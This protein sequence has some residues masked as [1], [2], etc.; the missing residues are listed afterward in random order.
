MKL[1]ISLSASVYDFATLLHIS[2]EV[3]N[4]ENKLLKLGSFDACGM[5]RSV[6]LEDGTDRSSRN[7]GNQLP[8]CAT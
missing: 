2:F 4:W 3:G 1:I 6:T 5:L 8:A 7:F